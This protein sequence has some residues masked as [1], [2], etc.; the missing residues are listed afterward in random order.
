MKS[1]KIGIYSTIG[2][3]SLNKKFLSFANNKVSL[4]RLNM[5]HIDL[6][7]LKGQIQTIRKF[8]NIP[9]CIDTEGAQIRT[10]YNFKKKFTTGKNIKILKSKK[11]IIFKFFTRYRILRERKT[12]LKPI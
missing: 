3:T 4:L 6:K 11:N 5:S 12:P 8:S 2:P 1:N 10:K 9:I 7:N